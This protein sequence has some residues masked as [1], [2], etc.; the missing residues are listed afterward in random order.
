MAY[1]HDVI[2]VGA[3]AAGLTAAG[4]LARLGLRVALVERGAMGGECLNTGCVPS[5]ALIA[6]ARRA[7]EVRDSGRFGIRPQEP[8]IDYAAVRAHVTAAIATIAPHDSVERYEAWG[9]EVIR[10]AARFLDERALAVA[11][12]RLSAPRIVVAAGS[13]PRIP[14]I[15]GL[16]ALP[17]LT[18]ETIFDLPDLPRRL[19]ILGAGA[20]GM[21]LA[22][23]FRRLGAEIVVVDHS[24]PFA[25]DEPEAATLVTARLEAE[26]VRFRPD[27][28]VAHACERD[29]DIVLTLDTGEELVGSHLLVATGRVVALEGLDLAAAG[30]AADATG[31]AVDRRRR[32]SARGIYAIGD[33]R[34]GPRFT[35]VAGYEGARMVLEIGFGLPAA[36]DFKAMPRVAFTEPELAQVGM[37]E[38]EARAAGGRV[39]VQ[40]A[41]FADNDRAV[42]EGASDGFVKLV[43]RNG[44]PVGA[45]LVGAGAGE[46]AMPWILAIG[47]AKASLLGLSGAV[48]PYPTRAEIT[49]AVA[50][51]GSD[52]LVFSRWTRAWARLLARCRGLTG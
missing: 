41:G 10:G 42:T 45:C 39:E 13:R 20:I 2:V 34:R 50:F 12:R 25:K 4:G 47:R 33:C 51:A 21:E 6:A 7:H 9:V 46:L 30:I 29:G 36:I 8:D 35:H 17:Y 18:N 37:T 48:L 14:D 11:G 5:K 15:P 28:Q 24:R 23:A 1:T 3:G 16:A 32:T 44:R 38:A 49:K 22:Q 40:R 26:G 31:I 43:R 27:T 19:L 52:G